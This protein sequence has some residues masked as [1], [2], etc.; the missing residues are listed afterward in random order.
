MEKISEVFVFKQGKYYYIEYRL[1][2]HD[3]TVVKQETYKAIKYTT[4][5]SKL[6]QLLEEYELV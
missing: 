5:I 4:L 3:E 6:N 1:L 2:N